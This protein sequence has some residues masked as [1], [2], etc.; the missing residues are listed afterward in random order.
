MLG[1][2]LDGWPLVNTSCWGILVHLVALRQAVLIINISFF[3]VP[4]EMGISPILYPVSLLVQNLC[5]MSHP[6]PIVEMDTACKF[7]T[8]TCWKHCPHQH[9]TK[10]KSRINMNRISI[11][12]NV[13][14]FSAS[15]Q[16]SP[17]IYIFTDTMYFMYIQ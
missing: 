2:R 1:K 15:I 17:T 6:T 10:I 14:S 7:N 5:T 3:T 12:N 13:A 9:S 8:A 16:L 11:H 4:T